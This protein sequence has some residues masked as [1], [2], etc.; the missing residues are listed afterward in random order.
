MENRIAVYGG[1]FDP[2]TIAHETIIQH[3]LDTYSVVHVYVTDNDEKRYS[4]PYEDRCAML[5][6]CFPN[7]KIFKQITR[8][9]D[10]LES[11]YGSPD[12]MFGE[13]P[14][15]LMVGLDEL[16][17]LLAGKWKDSDKLIDKYSIR[18]FNRGNNLNFHMDLGTRGDIRPIF[19]PVP[20]VSSSE[21]R[22]DMLMCPLYEGGMVSPK[23]LGYIFEHRLYHQDDAVRHYMEECAEIARYSPGD[24]PKPS[25][26]VTSVIVNAV[27]DSRIGRE[28][29]VLLVR[30]KR[31]PFA[32]YWCLPGG[33][34]NPH[35]PIEHCCCREVHEETGLVLYPHDIQ[36]L[37]VYVPEDPRTRVQENWAYDVG[38]YARGIFDT[39]V[40]GDDDASEAAWF[41]MSVVRKT[42]LAF[43]HNRI[44]EDYIKAIG[45]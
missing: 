18:V 13:L 9:Y 1:A 15:D 42:P 12:A 3:L 19:I 43:H 7:L 8:T 41:P 14:V 22:N 33:F 38:V 6:K 29:H 30:R 45:G 21:V 44:L 24:Y 27:G 16:K 28:D 31:W 40:K 17:D 4:A 20:N 10:L 2:P 26:T 35:E 34:V 5:L 37:K 36:Q 39:A 32:N 11:T 23:V 25:L